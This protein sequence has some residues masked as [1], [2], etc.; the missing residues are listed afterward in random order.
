MFQIGHSLH[1]LLKFLKK[2]AKLVI[3]Y[4]ASTKGNVI[5]Q[6]CDIGTELLPCLADR[7]PR[8]HGA[9]TLGTNIPIIS[10]EEARSMKPDYF[11]VLPYHFLS[12]MAEREKEFIAGG[13]RFIVPVPTVQLVP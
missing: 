11:L 8:K 1:Y 12:E 6:Y 4:G 9:R 10:E 13:G 7:N 3:G 5:L 2:E